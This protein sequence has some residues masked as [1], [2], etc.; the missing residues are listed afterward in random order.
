M[1]RFDQHALKINDLRRKNKTFYLIVIDSS[2]S[3]PFCATT[4]DHIMLSFHFVELEPNSILENIVTSVSDGYRRVF[5][6]KL[7]R[8]LGFDRGSRRLFLIST[9]G[10]DFKKCYQLRTWINFSGKDR[11]IFSY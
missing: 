8:D 2:L 5:S 10:V 4:A 6:F 9:T 7:N 3:T 11:V 1:D